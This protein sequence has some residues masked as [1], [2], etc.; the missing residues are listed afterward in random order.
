[1]KNIMC[2][3]KKA[4]SGRSLRKKG[5]SRILCFMSCKSCYDCRQE[6]PEIKGGYIETAHTFYLLS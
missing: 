3:I 1:M 5:R 4:K 2:C 6:M